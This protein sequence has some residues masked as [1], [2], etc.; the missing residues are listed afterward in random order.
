MSP[1]DKLWRDLSD[2]T[3]WPPMP[4]ERELRPITAAD[5]DD[6]ALRPQ[7]WGA[8]VWRLDGDAPLDGGAKAVRRGHKPYKPRL[9]P[10]R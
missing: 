5:L 9:M 7:D 10:L 8:L 3:T 1:L 2:P 6:L 4:D